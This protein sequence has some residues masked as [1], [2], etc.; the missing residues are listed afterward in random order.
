MGLYDE[1]LLY[2]SILIYGMGLLSYIL[3]RGLGVILLV[4]SAGFLFA[5]STGF[6]Y[7]KFWGYLGLSLAFVSVLAGAYFLKTQH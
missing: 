5:G 7:S 3:H 2:W 4:A 1:K 6:I